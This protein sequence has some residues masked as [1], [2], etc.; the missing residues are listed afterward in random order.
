[1]SPE[2]TLNVEAGAAPATGGI[3]GVFRSVQGRSR[4]PITGLHAFRL[5]SGTPAHAP[6]MFRNVRKRQ[7][8][9]TRFAVGTV[10]AAVLIS[11]LGPFVGAAI[12]EPVHLVDRAVTAPAPGV[13]MVVNVHNAGDTSHSAARA[14]AA[15]PSMIELDVSWDGEHLV[16]AHALLPAPLRQDATDLVTGWSRADGVSAVLID[17]K[18]HSRAGTSHLV[19]FM[20][21]H[22]NRSLY[23]SSPDP[24][25][26]DRV[27]SG[28]PRVHGLLSLNN[29]DQ[30]EQL[31]SGDVAVP[32][33]VGVSAADNLLTRP[34]VAALRHR[35]LFVLVYSVNDM[36]RVDTLAGWGVRGITTDNLAIVRALAAPTS[37]PVTT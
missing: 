27:H 37:R 11:Y 18:T 14:V 19:T 8:I 5:P 10:A 15:H 36:H 20:R 22:P 6:A 2:G 21:A 30:V 24:Q 7:R 33:L 25:V 9:L 31:V 29:S 3:Q 28:D 23:L 34:V 16:V 12:P 32:G 4:R 1:M 35:G 13:P 26:L 17:A